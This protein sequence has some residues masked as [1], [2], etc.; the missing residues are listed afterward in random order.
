LLDAIVGLVHRRKFVTLVFGAG[1]AWPWQAKGQQ[2]DRLR[3]IGVLMNV[4][5]S[6]AEGRARI[7]ALLQG[8]ERLGWVADRNVRIDTRWAAGRADNFRTYAKELLA[9]DP[10]VIVASPL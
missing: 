10:E 2:P 3:R 7:T 9:L 4:E 5:A 8:L 6:H 1:A